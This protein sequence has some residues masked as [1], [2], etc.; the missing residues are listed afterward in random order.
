MHT[1][2]PRRRMTARGGRPAEIEFAMCCGCGGSALALWWCFQPA[3]TDPLRQQHRLW[4]SMPQRGTGENRI[5]QRRPGLCEWIEGLL[6]CVC[7]V[8]IW[9]G[10][11]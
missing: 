1:C 6:W 8:C 10:G 4:R 3:P 7:V 2:P 9:G 5:L 11:E